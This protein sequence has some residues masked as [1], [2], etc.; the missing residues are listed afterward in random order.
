MSAVAVVLG[1]GPGVGLAVA[2]RFARGGYALAMMARRSDALAEYTQTLQAS[3]AIAQ[4]FAVDMGDT[5]AIRSALQSVN[6]TMGAPEVLV[7]NAAAYS[8]G[9]PSELDA[10]QLLDSFRV[11]VV[12]AMAA[13]QQVIPQ[14]R[15]QRRGTILFTGGG[16]ALYPSAQYAA[17]SIGKG[18]IRSLA[19]MLAAE[20]A[21]DGIHVA[22]VTI[23]G[24]VQ[25]GTH[26][27][28]DTIAE[29]Y[30]TLHT[31]PAGSWETEIVYR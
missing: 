16:L 25:P 12:G 7:Y 14:M 20:L 13:A 3:G 10:E 1:V 23:A 27:D 17:L 19:L 11:N 26:F 21:P 29:T 18:G 5:A 9:L 2:G 15:A 4:G 28:P 31:Q 24:G 22:T 8:P 30:W 6:D